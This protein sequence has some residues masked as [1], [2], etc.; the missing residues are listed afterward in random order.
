M[1][2]LGLGRVKTLTA[3]GLAIRASRVE[4]RFAPRSGDGHRLVLPRLVGNDASLKSS[5]CDISANP[6]RANEG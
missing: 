2:E 6:K 1:S 4:S 5:H 3:V